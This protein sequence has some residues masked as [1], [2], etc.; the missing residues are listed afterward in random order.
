[1]ARRT[2]GMLGSQHLKIALLLQKKGRLTCPELAEELGVASATCRSWMTLLEDLGIIQ[3]YQAVI[4]PELAVRT[5]QRKGPTWTLSSDIVFGFITLSGLKGTFTDEIKGFIT[6]HRFIVSAWQ[7]QGSI[8]YLL[9]VLAPNAVE[10][11]RVGLDARNTFE[12]S[13]MLRVLHPVVKPFIGY[14]LS[15]LLPE[16]ELP[17]RKTRKKNFEA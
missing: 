8:D 6:R 13:E 15:L 11:E 2:Q 3:S 14:D 5:K 12:G 16:G 17:Q 1:M 4:D 10:F 9:H 7:L